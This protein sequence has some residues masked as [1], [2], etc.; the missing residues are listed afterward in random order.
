VAGTAAL[1]AQCKPAASVKDIKNA[2]FKN[3]ARYHNLSSKIRDGKILDVKKTIDYMCK[4]SAAP[5]SEQIDNT[6][7]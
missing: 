7:L 1:L 2:I 3:A 4:S 6:D 5:I